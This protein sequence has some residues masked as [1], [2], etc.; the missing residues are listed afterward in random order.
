MLGVLQVDA[1]TDRPFAGNPAGV[2]PDAA[3]LSEAQMQAVAAEMNLPGT[4]F[5]LPSA[6][7]GALA[8]L[9]YWSPAHELRYSGHTTLAA[10]HAL[11]EAGRVRGD[12]VRIET[13]RG[14]VDVEV[15]TGPTGRVIWQSTPLPALRPF[16]SA[17]APLTEAVGLA[18]IGLGRWAQPAL[19]PDDDLLIPASG[20][21]ALRALKPDLDRIAALARRLGLRG[22]CIVSRET[23]EPS[24]GSHCR[25]FAPHLGIA[26]D[27]AT[28]S[29]H[30]PLALWLFET[31]R[32]PVIRGHVE[33]TA[34]QGDLLG[35]PGRLQIDIEVAGRTPTRIRVGGTAVTVLTGSMRLPPA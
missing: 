34:E 33:F 17:L 12:R 1:F 4:A 14:V 5:V 16:P 31:G 35:R 30:A 21:E 24:S 29:V 7:A 2:V 28:G 18:P 11:V 23:F 27:L 8:R 26:E 9:R 15:R 22:L 20:L 3:P 19:T 32:L 13:A 25:F 6:D 10:V